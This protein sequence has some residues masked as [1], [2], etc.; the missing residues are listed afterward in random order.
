ME[1]TRSNT[2]ALACQKCT[3][4]QGLGLRGDSAKSPCDCVL[5]AIFRVCH[6]RFVEYAKTDGY[7]RQVR[8]E[9]QN[10]PERRGAWGHKEEEYMA[11]FLLLAKRHLTE[12]EYKIFRY[13]FLLGADWRL[14]ARKMHTERGDFF[15]SV[16]RIMKKM[17]RAYA[18]TEPYPLFPL[19]EYFHGCHREQTSVAFMP[20]PPKVVPIRPPVPP[21]PEQSEES[22]EPVRK[23]A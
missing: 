14:C 9:I 4:C 21:K 20:P 17:G 1:W 10:G 19:S 18:E 13:R 2:L 8:L 15:N 11:D 16:Y 7:L 23:V 5:R 12:E 22:D 3:H 6:A